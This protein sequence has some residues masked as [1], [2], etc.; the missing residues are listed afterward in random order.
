MPVAET[1]GAATFPEERHPPGI[2][3][4][5]GEIVEAENVVRP[6]LRRSLHRVK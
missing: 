3:E 6:L 1:D 2:T 5:H 4:M